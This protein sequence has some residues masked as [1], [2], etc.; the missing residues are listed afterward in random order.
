VGQGAAALER[1][2]VAGDYGRGCAGKQAWR[3]RA[4]S[5]WPSSRPAAWWPTVGAPLA[6]GVRPQLEQLTAHDER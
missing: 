4:A 5:R 1:C 6:R 3:A 2:G